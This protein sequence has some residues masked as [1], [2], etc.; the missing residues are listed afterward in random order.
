VRLS[1]D[2]VG[3]IQL[4]D[5]DERLDTVSRGILGLSVACARCH[6]HKFDPIQQKDYYR[7]LSV[8]AST[9]RALRPFF[10]IDPQTE[11]RFMCGEASSAARRCRKAAMDA[12]TT[13][14]GSPCS[15]L[16]AA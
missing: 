11:T 5:W 12:I 8:F 3:T 1:V 9:Q 16:A 7:L 15:W 6:D 10:T 2:V 14:T 13:R 4:N